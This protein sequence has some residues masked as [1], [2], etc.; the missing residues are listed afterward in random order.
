MKIVVLLELTDAERDAFKSAAGDN[1]I[2]FNND[3]HEYISSLGSE[4]FT[5]ADIIIGQ[6]RPHVLKTATRLKWLQSRSSGVD[7]YLKEGVLP[8]GVILTSA[9][10]AYGQ[11]V[12]EHVFAM[13]LGIMK[14]FPL[15]RDNQNACLWRDEGATLS[16][17]GAR[18]L[19]VGTGDLGSSFAKLCKGMGSYTVGIRRDKT[20]PAEGIDEMHGFED[21]DAELP[22]ADVVCSMLPHS[23]DMIGFFN[24]ERFKSM[25]KEAIFLNAGRGP[26]V[27]CDGLCRA[28]SEGWLFGAGLDTLP[29]EPFPKD[30]PLWRQKRVF[31]T[32]H[33]AGGDHIPSTNRQVN[34]IALDNLKAYLG[35]KP[36]RNR[37]K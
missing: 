19:V 18:V 34:A 33:T 8:E 21:I 28:L 22:K 3:K 36:M 10:G 32:P 29:T 16:P 6:P 1:E 11:A 25:K 20:K 26:I 37:M 7:I 31:I 4:F 35:G 9:T 17:D 13:M 23:D 30:D 2:V 24:Y 14:L 15:Y 5:D 12:S 27:D